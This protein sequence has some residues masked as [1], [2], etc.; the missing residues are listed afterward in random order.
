MV[1]IRNQLRSRHVPNA[2]WSLRTAVA[3]AGLIVALPGCNFDEIEPEPVTGI[4]AEVA[5]LR[6][7][8]GTQSVTLY[9]DSRLTLGP[10]N[11]ARPNAL[12]TIELLDGEGSVMDVSPTELQVNIGSEST[13][14]ISNFVR[15]DAFSG[16]LLATNA[17]GNLLNPGSTNLQVMLFD[18][19]KRRPVW[20]PYR[21]PIFTR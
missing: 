16:T 8:I 10:L 15:R 18:V 4:G 21:V 7:N 17:A 3:A 1:G 5:A 13:N 12:L 20:G 2:N 9:S 14:V 11:F 19:V 6:L